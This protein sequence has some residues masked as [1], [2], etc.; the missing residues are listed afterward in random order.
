MIAMKTVMT[1]KVQHVIASE[2]PVSYVVFQNKKSF[3]RDLKVAHSLSYF[4]CA[5]TRFDNM[6]GLPGH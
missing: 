5:K 2:Q 1:A 3:L 4:F 6:N